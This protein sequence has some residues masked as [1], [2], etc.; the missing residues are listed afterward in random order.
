VIYALYIS[1][2]RNIPGPLLHRISWVPMR[3]M[4]LLGAEQKVM[5]CL[6][7]KYGNVFVLEPTRIALGDPGDCAKVL[8][9]H[10]FRKDYYYDR[11]EVFEPNTLLTSDPGLNSH[12]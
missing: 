9:T 12:R 7:E 11:V 5:R 8:S 2:V 3:I 1:P 10:A 6:Y 4:E